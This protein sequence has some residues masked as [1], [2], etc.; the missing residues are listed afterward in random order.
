M[1]CRRSRVAPPPAPSTPEIPPEM[2]G[3]TRLHAR[4]KGVY[5][6]EVHQVALRT[7]AG[8]GLPRTAAPARQGHAPG[9]RCPRVTGLP[10]A[11]RTAPRLSAP[12]A[13]VVP[14]CQRP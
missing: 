12:L 5:T 2:G 7:L 9:P 14:A 4:T 11:R 10:S 13:G 1:R 8:G 6:L 3:M